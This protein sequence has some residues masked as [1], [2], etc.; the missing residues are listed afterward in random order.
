MSV[1]VLTHISVA[2]G[3]GV[4]SFIL[5]TNLLRV[6]ELAKQE[7]QKC[8][9]QKKLKNFAWGERGAEGG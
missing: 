3:V 2:A 5:A 1:F 4:R 7:I 8:S 9:I 6:N